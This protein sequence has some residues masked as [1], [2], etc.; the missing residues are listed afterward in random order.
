MRVGQIRNAGLVALLAAAAVVAAPWADEVRDHLTRDVET[1][2]DDAAR[3]ATAR[4]GEV[5]RLEWKLGGFFGVL[6][7]L[8]VPST[9]KALLTF[10]PAAEE[11][12][13]IQLLV[14]APKR[15]G[16]Y[17]LY[18]ASIEERSG[19]LASVWSSSEFHGEYEAREQDIDGENIIDYSSVIWRLRWHPPETSTRMTIWSQG[20][21]YPANIVPLGPSRRKIRGE[22]ID[23]RG[24]LVRGAKVDGKRSFD[25]SIYVYYSH[26]ANA[27]P[28]EIV[29]KRGLIQVRIR[30]VGSE[31]TVRPPQGATLVSQGASNGPS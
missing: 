30:L 16:E 9:G 28:V 7:G 20:K 12:T 10:V 1:G 15:K 2:H 4:G 8:F 31:G 19:S 23:V 27:T 18:G 17:M 11:Q 26:D 14:T 29:G 13:E 5:L 6:A 22:K 24:Y 21:I 3:A 25:D